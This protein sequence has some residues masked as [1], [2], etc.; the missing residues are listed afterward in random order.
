MKTWK[1]VSLSPCAL[2]PRTYRPLT[3]SGRRIANN[4]S[5]VIKKIWRRLRCPTFPF[6]RESNFITSM[7]LTTAIID[8]TTICLFI[9]SHCLDTYKKSSRNRARRWTF[10][11]LNRSSQ[12]PFGPPDVV[13]I[14]LHCQSHSW[15]RFHMVCTQLC[16]RPHSILTQTSV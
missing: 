8:L 7:P 2:A 3:W 1:Y 12:S 6:T 10:T 14:S 9:L 4:G 11:T 5:K 13:H 16:C 15:K